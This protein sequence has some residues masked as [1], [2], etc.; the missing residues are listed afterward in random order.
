MEKKK[1]KKKYSFKKIIKNINSNKSKF[2]LSEVLTIMIISILIG[3]LLG[4]SI[5]Y[6]GDNITVTKVSEDL[7]ELI[8]TYNDIYNNYY[9]KV[10]KDD[11]INSAIKGM[12][13]YLDDPYSEFLDNEESTIFNESVDGEYVGIGAVVSYDGEYATISS[14]F[15]NSPSKKAGMEVGDKLVEI[16]GKKIIG[17]NSNEISNLIKGKVGSKIVI[18][19][20]RGD[21]EK[22]FT[23]KREKIS[24][25]SVT[26]KVI[27]SNNKNIGYIAIDIFSANTDKQ[28]ESE[29]KKLEKKK[30]DS[31]IIDVRSNP[32]GHLLE[33]TNILDLFMKKN[34]VLYRVEKK[35]ISKKIKDKTR[36]SRTYPIVVLI[37]NS[38][39]SASEILA[40]SLKE[41]YGA[42]LVGEKSYGK[43]TVQSAYQLSDG[44]TLK[45]TT[46]KWLTSKGV[47][48]N[49]KGIKPDYEEVLGEEYYNNPN[50][51]NDNQL[52]KAIEI[53]SN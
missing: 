43:G 22:E 16:D 29:L 25:P 7:E 53:L 30:I 18:K 34:Q 44:T 13:D 33:V 2:N 38:S 8:Y 40:S 19:V 21:E 49:E 23:L 12:I 50:D 11:L 47:W 14:M 35:N 39:A 3:F 45:Y 31:L 36:A 42:K 46:Q 17:L 26:S 48:I 28:F 32:G 10:D 5:S 41:V 6:S 51:E 37:N 9:N 20:L 27:K 4:S 52:Q 15:T 24:V 1:K